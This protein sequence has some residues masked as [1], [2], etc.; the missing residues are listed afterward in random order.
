MKAVITIEIECSPAAAGSIRDFAAIACV[1]V[2][3]VIESMVRSQVVD[4]VDADLAAR[5]VA[6]GTVAVCLQPTPVTP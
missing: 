2:H 5:G 1:P 4:L 6:I 3:K